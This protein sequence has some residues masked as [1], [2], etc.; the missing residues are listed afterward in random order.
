MPSRQPRWPS[1]G[2]ASCSA[3]ARARSLRRIGAGGAR[4]FLDFLFLVRQEF[5][6]RRIE[7]TDG[8][9][10]ARHVLE[11]RREI[12]ALHRQ[13]LG[14]R[15]SALLLARRPGSSGAPQ[16]CGRHRRTCA[17]CGKGRCLRRRTCAPW[18]HRRACRH[19]CAP[20]GGA[21]ASAQPISVPKSPVSSGWR[22]GTVPLN[23]WPAAAIDGD[24]VAA[25]DDDDL[26]PP[27]FALARYR[28]SEMPAPETQ[29]RPMP[30]ATT[31]A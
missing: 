17:R 23:T 29:G 31:A 2:L 6:Q 19:W 8:D 9:G 4:H 15:G 10:Q 30:R 3:M 28:S 26:P 1:M 11:D 25:R 20:S 27:V 16:R 7:Q 12:A 13:Q 14:Q 22:I 21:T 18:R 24:D 5:V